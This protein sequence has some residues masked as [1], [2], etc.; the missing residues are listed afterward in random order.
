MPEATSEIIQAGADARRYGLS[1]A[2]T[3]RLAKPRS[4]A[5][6]YQRWCLALY[7]EHRDDDA[8]PTGGRFLWYEPVQRGLVDKTKAPGHPGVTGRWVDQ[9]IAD[10]LKVIRQAGLVPWE[11]IIDETRELH[12]WRGSPT[13]LTGVRDLLDAIRLDPWHSRPPLLLV[14]SRQ[15]AAVL[16][17]VVRDSRALLSGLGGQVHGHLVTDIVPCLV[18]GQ[19]ILYLGDH[20]LVGQQIE[21]NVLAVLNQHNLAEAVTFQRWR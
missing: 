2:V 4:A 19:P 16:A 15:T 3:S 21:Q 20:D 7:L 9:N 6:R 12:D 17:P 1:P 18:P 13:V 11:D 14:E 5:R 10:A 8:L